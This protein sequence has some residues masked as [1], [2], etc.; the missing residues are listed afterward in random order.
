MFLLRRLV[1]VPGSRRL[2]CC[3]TNASVQEQPGHGGYVSATSSR[4][5]MGPALEAIRARQCI[6][7][8]S[9]ANRVSE[10]MAR[11]GTE[12]GQSSVGYCRIRFRPPQVIGPDV[13]RRLVPP[14]TRALEREHRC[15]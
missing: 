15:S 13:A 7:F 10:F 6:V 9:N 4:L 1:V 5:A 2:V 12:T 11:Y 8:A 3:S 14:Y